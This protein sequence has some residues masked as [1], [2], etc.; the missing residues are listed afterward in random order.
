MEFHY[1]IFGLKTVRINSVEEVDK[2]LDDVLAD[3]HAVLCEVM[4]NKDYAFAPKL[5]AKTLPDG[6]MVSP[7]LENMFPFLP[8]DELKSNMLN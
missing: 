1:L 5:S 4:L 7:S 2:K 6:T 3:K 8:E